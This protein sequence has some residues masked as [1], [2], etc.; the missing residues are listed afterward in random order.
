MMLGRWDDL[1]LWTGSVARGDDGV[2]RLFYGEL[3]DL[4]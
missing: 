1:A 3:I 4:R 2:W